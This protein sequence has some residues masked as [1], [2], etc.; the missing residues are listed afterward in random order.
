[1]GDARLITPRKGKRAAGSRRK[2]LK[3]LDGYNFRVTPGYNT[4]KT[5]TP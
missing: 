4:N 1:M 3:A 5:P 2:P